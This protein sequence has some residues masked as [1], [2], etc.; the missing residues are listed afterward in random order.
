[1]WPTSLS[2]VSKGGGMWSPEALVSPH[3]GL[4]GIKG[5]YERFPLTLSLYTTP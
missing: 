1:V 2:C 5:M 3:F 4:S